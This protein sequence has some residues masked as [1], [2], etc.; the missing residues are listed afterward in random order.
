MR[1]TNTTLTILF[2]VSVWMTIKLNRAIFQVYSLCFWRNHKNCNKV[3]YTETFQIRFVISE[4]IEQISKELWI[5]P[6]SCYIM[7]QIYLIKTFYSRIIYTCQIDTGF[8]Q[9]S[10]FFNER[11]LK[12][13]PNFQFLLFMSYFLS[14]LHFQIR[15]E[16][17]SRIHIL[18]NRGEIL[19]FTIPALV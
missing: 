6:W 11:K 13:I 15:T 8:W 14:G 18:S 9:V 19:H 5:T 10:Q 1:G 16:H 7:L 12:I 2:S 4:N 17:N 3:T